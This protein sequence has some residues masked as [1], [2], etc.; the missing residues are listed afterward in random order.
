MPPPFLPPSYELLLRF[1]KVARGNLV[2][3]EIEMEKG[4]KRRHVRRLSHSREIFGWWL[5]RESN[6]RY[7][8]FQ[9]S[10]LTTLLT[11]GV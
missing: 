10:V 7:E 2:R 9:S 1:K 8:D 3:I 4:V 6:P 11:H 5:G